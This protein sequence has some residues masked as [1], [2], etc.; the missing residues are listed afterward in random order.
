MINQRDISSPLLR[1]AP[2]ILM[3]IFSHAGAVDSVV[4]ALSCRHLLRIAHLCRLRVCDRESHQ[5]PW[6]RS[7]PPSVPRSRR[8][9][10]AEDLLQRLPPKDSR[11]RPSRAWNLCV[12]CLRYRPTRRAYWSQEMLAKMNNGEEWDGFDGDLRSAWLSA[13]AWFSTKVKVQCPSCHLQEALL[14]ARIAA[15]A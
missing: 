12:D 15:S 7:P 6:S 13:V 1:L 5:A 3:H 14:A 9:R 10:G 11:G 8:C 4:L 2:E